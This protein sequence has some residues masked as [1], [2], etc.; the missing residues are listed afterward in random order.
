MKIPSVHPFEEYTCYLIHHKKMNRK[1][2]CLVSKIDNTKRRTILYAKFLMSCHLGR[3][4]VAE[5]QVGHIDN[6]KTNDVIENL[7]ILSMDENLKKYAATL[8]RTMVTLNCEQCGNDFTVERRQTHLVKGGTRTLCS[9]KCL[10]S[11]M[12]K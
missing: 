3:V 8:S 9:R 2:V 10:Y 11:S 7:Q 12:K 5:E 1:Q 4:L 6:D